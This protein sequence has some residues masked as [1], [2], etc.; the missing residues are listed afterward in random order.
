MYMDNLIK[1]VNEGRTAS[2]LDE[3][4]LWWRII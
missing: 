1:K 3:G 2:S 4:R